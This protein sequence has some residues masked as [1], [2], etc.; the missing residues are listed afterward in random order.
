MVTDGRMDG[1]MFVT[2]AVLVL[3][4]S[5]NHNLASEVG[6][7]NVAWRSCVAKY[8]EPTV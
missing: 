5:A 4:E 6:F 3:F 7:Q 8:C 2:A 1:C